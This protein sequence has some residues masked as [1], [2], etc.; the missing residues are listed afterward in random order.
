M[1]EYVDATVVGVVIGDITRLLVTEVKAGNIDR[2]NRSVVSKRVVRRASDST[3]GQVV[4]ELF[5]SV[6]GASA[7]V[8]V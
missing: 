2:G 7:F 5:I 6:G 3:S 4:A 8:G 1:T